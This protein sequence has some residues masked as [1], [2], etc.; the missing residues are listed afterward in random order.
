[1]ISETKID[2]TFPH[3]QF[4]SQCFNTPFSLDRNSNSVAFFLNVREE[5]PSKLL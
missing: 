5:I 3:S 2:T 1:M 4:S